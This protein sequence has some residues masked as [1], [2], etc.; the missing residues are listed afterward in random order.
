MFC[1][2]GLKRF[3]R[4]ELNIIIFAAIVT[5]NRTRTIQQLAGR[6]QAAEE[7]MPIIPHCLVGTVSK[8]CEEIQKRRE[9]YGIS[10]LSV[11]EESAEIFAPV[12]ARLTGE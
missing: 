12:V 3:A 7:Q 4:L 9:Q 6:F 11:F 8:I 1:M 10:Y 5:E 2:P